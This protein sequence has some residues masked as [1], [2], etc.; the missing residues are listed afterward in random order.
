MGE[1]L[2]VFFGVV[3][4]GFIGLTGPDQAVVLPLLATQILWINLVTDSARRW[5]WGSIRRRTTSW[6]ASRAAGREDDRRPHVGGGIAGGR[7]D[8]R[9]H[10][11]HPRP[12][13][14][15][16]VSSKVPKPG[17]RAHGRLHVLVLA[18]LFNCFNARSD[19]A[20]A[21]RHLLANRWLLGAIL[22][23]L[24]L[25][26]AVVNIPFLNVAFGTVPLD[27]LNGW[28]ASGWR[29]WSCGRAS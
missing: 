15:R 25:Q 17:Q 27:R 10:A 24:L 1:V 2:T 20:S 5:R 12:V 13:P 7:G 23:A 3:L 26:V 6:R 22:L 8:G 4:A 14:A 11:A 9:G 28:S 29:A 19:K 21:F 16:A 18:Q